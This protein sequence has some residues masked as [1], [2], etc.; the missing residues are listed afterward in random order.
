[1]LTFAPTVLRLRAE[2]MAFDALQWKVGK[3]GAGARLADPGPRNPVG[4]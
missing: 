1:M 2:F 4:I 3:C